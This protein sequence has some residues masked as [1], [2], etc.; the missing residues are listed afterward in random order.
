MSLLL[1]EICLFDSVF[2]K[3]IFKV[4]LFKRSRDRALRVSDRDGAPP[5]L[6][7]N[8]SASQSG[9]TLLSR[10]R[11][12]PGC[13]TFGLSVGARVSAYVLCVCERICVVCV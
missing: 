4:L 11:A 10:G 13:L 2:L 12:P 6:G 1:T 3:A 5:I 8:A 7:G 9:A